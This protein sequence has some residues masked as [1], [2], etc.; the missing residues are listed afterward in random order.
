M[1]CR[2][3]D[4]REGSTSGRWGW[5]FRSL[6]LIHRLVKQSQWPRQKA[7]GLPWEPLSNQIHPLRWFKHQKRLTSLPLCLFRGAAMHISELISTALYHQ[8]CELNSIFACGNAQCLPRCMGCVRLQRALPIAACP[9]DHLDSPHLPSESYSFVAYE[10]CYWTLASFCV[11][12]Q[13]NHFLHAI[14]RSYL[15]S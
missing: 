13:R 11:A 4:K 10:S 1:W 5:A 3:Y 7:R 9:G 8:Q 12:P 2:S 14:H 15:P 6:E